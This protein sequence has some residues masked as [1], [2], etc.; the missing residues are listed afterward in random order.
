MLVLRHLYCRILIVCKSHM[1]FCNNFILYI[2]WTPSLIHSCYWQL[3]NLLYKYWLHCEP[4][5]HFSVWAVAFSAHSKCT[6]KFEIIVMFHNTTSCTVKHKKSEGIVIL[7]H[8]QEPPQ[9]HAALSVKILCYFQEKCTKAFYV[10]QL[11]PSRCTLHHFY[12]DYK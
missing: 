7:K 2:I 6:I 9:Y 8:V 12:I 4:G 3:S 10:S 1:P 5:L 11:S